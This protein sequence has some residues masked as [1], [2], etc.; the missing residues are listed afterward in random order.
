MLM[1]GFQ[2]RSPVTMGLANETIQQVKDF[3]Q[4][5]M[6]MLR[7]AHQNVRQ[8]QDHYKKFAHTKRGLVSFEEGDLMFLRMPKHSQS[9]KIGAMPKFLSQFCK[10]FGILKK[11]GKVAYK[12]EL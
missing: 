2:P 12:L 3:L 4:D 10:P 6:D 9:F 5:H 1:Y 8:A 7:L 11:I